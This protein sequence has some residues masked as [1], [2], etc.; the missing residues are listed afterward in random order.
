MNNETVSGKFDQASGKIK[1]VVG[2][3]VGNEKL[4]NAGVAEQVKGAA[5]ETWGHAKD[6]ANAVHDDARVRTNVEGRDLKSRA[7]DTAHNVRESIASTARNAKDN[8]N[9]KLDEIKREHRG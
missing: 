1:Q 8:I 4:A 3:A 7:E 6:A 9:A 5:K 2:E